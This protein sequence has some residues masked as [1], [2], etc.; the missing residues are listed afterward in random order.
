MDL[1]CELIIEKLSALRETI[2]KKKPQQMHAR[3]FIY[4][5]KFIWRGSGDLF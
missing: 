1:S 2:E 3:A 4:P 5:C